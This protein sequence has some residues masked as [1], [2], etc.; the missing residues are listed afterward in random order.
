MFSAKPVLAS[1]DFDSDTAKCIID[2]DGGWVIEPESP[3][4]LAE[5]IKKCMKL[6]RTELEDKG[7]KGREFALRNLSKD[8]NL[9]KLVNACIEVIEE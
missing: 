1:V 7:W 6:S 5:Q 8:K 3:E 2:C 9:S 4:H